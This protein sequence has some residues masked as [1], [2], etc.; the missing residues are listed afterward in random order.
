MESFAS[1]EV[2]AESPGQDGRA[3]DTQE[4]RLEQAAE[5]DV[6]LAGVERRAFGVARMVLRDRDDALD[7]VQQA[8]LQLVRR[9]RDRPPQEWNAVFHRI[10][11]NA[12][13]DS[14]RRRAVRSKIF[15]LLPG[16]RRDGEEG[17]EDPMAQVADGAPDPARRVA[18]AEAMQVLESA[19]AE[20]PARQREAFVLRCLEGLDVRE[21]ASTM[22]CSEGSVKTHYFRALATLRAQLGEVW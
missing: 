7:V 18:T 16:R 17:A 5:L 3:S 11:W 2:A 4:C 6:F 12:I 19:L 20:L 15:F 1:L 10:L 21:T 13:R 22:G 14:Q 9:Y 8:M